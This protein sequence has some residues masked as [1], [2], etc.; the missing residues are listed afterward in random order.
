[1]DLSLHLVRHLARGTWILGSGA[2]PDAAPAT[3]TMSS[4]FDDPVSLFLPMMVG[5]LPMAAAAWAA[6]FWLVRRAVA[7]YQQLRKM[8][9]ARKRANADAAEP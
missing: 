6:S 3:L 9:I 4:I 8:R 2:S 7:R 5:G 1:M